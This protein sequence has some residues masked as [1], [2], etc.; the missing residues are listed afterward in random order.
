MTVSPGRF[1]QGNVQRAPAFLYYADY[2]VLAQNMN[3]VSDIIPTFQRNMTV[4]YSNSSQDVSITATSSRFLAVRSYEIELGRFI[5]ENDRASLA[6]VAVI[7]S[8][9]AKDFYSGLNPIGRLIKINGTEFEVVGSSKEKGS[10]GFG[11][12]DS[13]IIVPLETGYEKLFGSGAVNNGKLRLTD[14]AMS[15]VTPQAVNDVLVQVERILRSQHRLSLSDPMDF[16]V[17]SQRRFSLR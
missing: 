10:S 8:Q 4:T 5:T 9:T 1:Q 17:N 2:E 11:N 7:G 14:I 3:N 12:V 6:R 15:A 13:I 16:S